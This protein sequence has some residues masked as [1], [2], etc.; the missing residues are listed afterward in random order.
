MNL[1]IG[2][3]E[4]VVVNT[5]FFESGLGRRG[6]ARFELLVFASVG[7]EALIQVVVRAANVR[8]F[9]GAFFGSSEG[10]VARGGLC[11]GSIYVSRCERPR[12]LESE[13]GHG[14]VF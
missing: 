4:V 9:K 3:I 13:G 5:L 6:V 12:A 2:R 1:V 8:H 14:G 10:V 7:L 11:D